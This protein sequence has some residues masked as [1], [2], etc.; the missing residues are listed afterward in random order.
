MIKPSAIRRFCKNVL[1]LDVK[2]LQCCQKLAMTAEL[3]FIYFSVLVFS[4]QLRTAVGVYVLYYWMTHPLTQKVQTVLLLHLNINTSW[5]LNFGVL[6]KLL[7]SLIDLIQV[8]PPAGPHL[9]PSLHLML[10]VNR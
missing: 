10:N 6:W 8:R 3:F 5:E 9:S 2:R 1:L 7:D 4:L